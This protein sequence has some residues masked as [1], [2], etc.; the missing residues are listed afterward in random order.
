M[1]VPC[2]N[3]RRF[4]IAC[5]YSVHL[6]RRSLWPGTAALRGFDVLRTGCAGA[7]KKQRG[8]ISQYFHLTLEQYIPTPKLHTSYLWCS[9]HRP[10]CLSP[11]LRRTFLSH[12][13]RLTRWGAGCPGFQDTT[14]RLNNP[15]LPYLKHP[16]ANIWPRRSYLFSPRKITDS[17]RAS[18]VNVVV[19]LPAMRSEL[20]DVMARWTNMSIECLLPPHDW[21]QHLGVSL[22]NNSSP[23][24][25]VGPS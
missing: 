9:H 10:R 14:L 25:L 1:Y 8:L 6:E 13:T 21:C 24:V 23:G 18:V 3:F 11:F 4:L 12:C 19:L 15:R 2:Q 7:A 5:K 17:T 16:H 22:C 20:T